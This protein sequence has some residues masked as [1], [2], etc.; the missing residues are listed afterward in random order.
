MGEPNTHPA[1]NREMVD[2][3]GLV[4]SSSNESGM[5][6]LPAEVELATMRQMMESL[7]SRVDMLQQNQA[8]QFA[9]VHDRLDA[10]EL[11]LPLVQ[12]QSALRI[13]DLEARMSVEIE[14][15]A[16]AAVEEATAG[17][18][19]EVSGKFGSLAS[20][21]ESQRKELTQMR[22]SKKLA[23]TKLNRV[24]Q[25][26]ERLCGNLAP[27]PVEEVYRPVVEAP[28]SPFRTRVAEHI[29]RAAVDAAP[30]ESN[31]LIGD[32][33]LKKTAAEMALTG[34]ETSAP[35]ISAPA[36]STFKPTVP[37][38]V[39]TAKP[40]AAENVVPG[41][42]DWKRQFMQ[43]GDPLNPTLV[44]EGDKKCNAVVCPRGYSDRTR[45]ATRTRLDGLFRLT[46]FIPHRC[47]SCAHRFYKRGPAGV[48]P[49]DE[50]NS[51]SREEILETR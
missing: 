43:D 25:D 49:L 12:E 44:P 45:P 28:A 4:L 42:D 10:V 13:R 33:A 20:Q 46:G 37:S 1:D 22:D 50:E 11:E 48:D 7:F 32:P 30:D 6:R 19:E 16:R 23:E 8:V 41:F 17:L 36:V 38:I 14:E 2:P 51:E 24:V 27:R 47:R 29:R 34:R 31:P 26:I 21:I 35:V 9:G 18:Q 15:A 5:V 40:V 39:A 3:A